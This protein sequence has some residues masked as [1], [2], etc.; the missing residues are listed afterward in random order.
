[1]EQAPEKVRA[2]EIRAEASPA[3]SE[4]VHKSHMFFPLRVK[5]AM[6]CVA[7]ALPFALMYFPDLIPLR[8]PTDRNLGLIIMVAY[9]LSLYAIFELAY[10]LPLRRI[11]KWFE[12]ARA[13]SFKNVSIVPVTSSDE[14]GRLARE[15][16]AAVSHFWDSEKRV[17][18]LLSQKS[19]T[20][21]LIEHQL[22]TPLTALLWSVEKV[23]VPQEVQTAL[24]RMKTLVEAIVEASRI[25]EGKFGYVFAN[26]DP[27]PLIEKAVARFKPFAESKNVT[28]TFEH[29]S[30]I[31]RVRADE[32]RMDIVMASLLSNAVDYTP[33]GGTVTVSAAPRDR[34]LEISVADTGIGIPSEE[35]P[36]LFTKLYR[37]ANAKKMRPDGSGL[38]LFVVKNILHAHGSEIVIHS[39]ERRGTRVSFNLPFAP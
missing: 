37:G 3:Q 2:E 24:L 19:D 34:S 21:S 6:L 28:L 8:L 20:M 23:H 17:R 32:D 29:D 15:L 30:D 33:N 39:Q 35:L 36:H 26:V 31:P 16:G 18:A 5:L 12:R 4:T 11:L 22:R 1:M 13:S 38:G 9:A 10:V 7:A 25:E 14:L 27:L